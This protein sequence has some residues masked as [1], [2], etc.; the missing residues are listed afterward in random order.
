MADPTLP[1]M[2]N[3]TVYE[4]A[5]LK[6][7][8]LIS[9]PDFFANT[10]HVIELPTQLLVIDGQFFAPYGAEVRGFADS[11]GKPVTRFYIS[12]DHP[13][14]YLGFG[15]A[16]PD[17]PVYALPQI[18]ASIRAEGPAALAARQQAFGPLIA[19]TL[20]LP[21]YDVA[22]GTETVD[23]VTFAFSTAHDNEAAVSLV[24]RLPEHGV[25]IVQDI[26]YNGVHLFVTGPTT[27]WRKALESLKADPG[28][29]LVLP[30]HGEPG[31]KEI[32][33]VSLAYL[34]T[35]DALVAQRVDSAAYKASLLDRYPAY[36]GAALI[37]IYLPILFR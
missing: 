5:G 21:R 17:V 15:D 29:S 34:D 32:I 3:R 16:F 37:D 25:A 28:V 11:L 10:T 30:G 14:H 19:R 20:N 18:G 36:G 33:D 6:I 13:D 22:E 9:P 8:T 23:G 31:G 12:H 4:G 27:G 24:I 1:P 26:V 35:V 7:H 2:T